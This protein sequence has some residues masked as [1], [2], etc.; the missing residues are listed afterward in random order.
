[1][2]FLPHSKAQNGF[3]SKKG[4]GGEEKPSNEQAK[5]TGDNQKQGGWREKKNIIIKK[6]GDK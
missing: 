3:I 2:E 4:G 1:M 6:D 5:W